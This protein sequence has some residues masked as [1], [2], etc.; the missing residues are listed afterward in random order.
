MDSLSDRENYKAAMSAFRTLN[1]SQQE[2]AVLWKTLAA[3]LHLVRR[4]L[5]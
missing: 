3:I 2:I 1:F 4:L 5:Q